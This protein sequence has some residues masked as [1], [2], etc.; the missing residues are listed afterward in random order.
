[1]I[2]SEKSLGKMISQL[3]RVSSPQR[4]S[5]HL[6]FQVSVQFQAGA[7]DLLSGSFH[8]APRRDA[9]NLRKRPGP[10]HQFGKALRATTRLPPPSRRHASQGDA[11]LMYTTHRS[12]MRRQGRAGK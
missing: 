11:F 12:E 6:L 8:G 3:A 7:F 4:I 9:I 1:M 5:T 2:W 10:H